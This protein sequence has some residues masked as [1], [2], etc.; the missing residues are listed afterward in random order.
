LLDAGIQVVLADRKLP[1]NQAD[2]VVGDNL[3][4][5]I[6]AVSHLIANGY[7]RIAC[8]TG[9]LAATTSAERLFGYRTALQQAGITL[10]DSLVRVADFREAGGQQAM[11]ELLSQKRPP[12]AVFIANNRMAAGALQAIEEAKKTIPD[13]IAVIGFDEIYWAPL[14]RTALTTVSQPAYDL[15]YESVHLLLNRLNGYS[16]SVRTVVLP[17]QLNIRASS[18]PK[19]ASSGPKSGSAAGSGPIPEAA[20][21]LR[22]PARSARKRS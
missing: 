7:R 3:S 13:E 11:Q 19:R 6:E 2:T 16:G 17:T 15:G 18:G 22:R 1:G 20:R 8:I 12:E 4:G 9:P 21:P 14:L 5:A 10:E